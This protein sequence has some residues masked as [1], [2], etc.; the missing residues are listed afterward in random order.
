MFTNLNNAIKIQL[1]IEHERKDL[2]VSFCNL[3]VARQ[4][5]TVE[6]YNLLPIF[7]KFKTKKVFSDEKKF[8]FNPY[9]NITED[10]EN[11]SAVLH[12]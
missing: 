4:K 1:D 2:S 11:T 5:G 6:V 10:C 7:E 8:N 9:R 3:F 12:R